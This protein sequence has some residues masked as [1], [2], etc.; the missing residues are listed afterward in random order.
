M[1]IWKAVDGAPAERLSGPS[2]V[3]IGVFDG[4]HRGHQSVLAAVRQKADEMGA[5][6]VAI[7]FD[8]HPVAVLAPQK[9]PKRLTTIERRV[10]LLRGHGA[11][12]VRV[13]AFS[14]EMSAWTPEEFIQRV[15]VDQVGCRHLIV[16]ENF[17]FGKRAAG[18]VDTLREAG[19]RD[20]FG[21][22]GWTLVGDGKA[23]SST[24]ARAA[25]AAGDMTAAA[26]VLGRPHELSG[27]VVPGD[28]RGRQLGYPTANMPVDESFAVPPDGVYAAHLVRADGT[29]LPAAVSVGTN[30]TFEG[31]SG[32]RVESYVLDR[33]DLDLYGEAVRVEFVERLRPMVAFASVDALTAQ[34]DEDVAATRRVLDA[35]H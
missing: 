9:A 32:R 20:G 31:V 11:G 15:V 7:T 27:T 10:E 28:R 35:G 34:M 23:F 26:A 30:P 13:L 19:A 29:R 3:T 18:S 14:A 12:E 33:D 17:R 21:V 5:T 16:G 2:V 6:A 24:R 25:I 1:A 22:E 4:V 8:P